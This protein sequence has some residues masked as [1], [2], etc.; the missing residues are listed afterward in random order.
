MLD[1]SRSPSGLGADDRT[2]YR[3]V[4]KLAR[5]IRE[6]ARLKGSLNAFGPTSGRLAG[7]KNKSGDRNVFLRA[8]YSPS[9][10]NQ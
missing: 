5:R 8:V 3:N 6:F 1:R 9:T 4:V 7:D 10:V 2:R